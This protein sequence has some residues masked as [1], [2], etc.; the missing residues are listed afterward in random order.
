MNSYQTFL[1]L[2]TVQLYVSDDSLIKYF[3]IGI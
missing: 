1:L 3:V 2:D